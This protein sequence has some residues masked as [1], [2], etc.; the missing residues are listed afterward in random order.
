[1]KIEIDTMAATVNVSGDEQGDRRYRLYSRDAF[2]L[3][4]KLWLKVGW[5]EKYP[6]SF[7]WLGR[8]IIQLPEDVMRI[9]EV[10]YRVKPDVIME[11]GVAHGGS[12]ILYASLCKAM[13]RG[14]V[15]GID[16]EIRKHN[17]TAIEAH[18]LSSGITL[19]EGSSVAPE[20]VAQASGLVKP[21][22]CVLVILDSNHSY[23][24]VAA[25]L[26][27]YAP[28]VTPGSYIVATDGSMESLSD[29]PRGH[30]DWVTDNPAAAARDFAARHPEFVLEQ[31]AW[32]FNESALRENITHWPSAWLRRLP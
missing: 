15:V 32:P 13:G 31:P 18:E 10:I 24:H 30:P 19:I 27:A 23:A 22:E 3:L 16:I 20:V 4:S 5:N 9:Q 28:L 26:E 6:Y 21:G 7:S 29:V 17:R 8:P 25:E 1:M 11:T 12:L 14:R 2:E